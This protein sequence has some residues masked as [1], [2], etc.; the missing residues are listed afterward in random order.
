MPA[1]ADAPSPPSDPS[2][3][4]R[5]ISWTDRFIQA[6]A[7]AGSIAGIATFLTEHPTAGLRLIA[8]SLLAGGVALTFR[9]RTAGGLSKGFTGALALALLGAGAFGWSL[10]PGGASDASPPTP[11]PTTLSSPPATTRPTPGPAP[12]PGSTS[13]TVHRAETTVPLSARTEIDLDSLAPDWDIAGYDETGR[14]DLRFSTSSLE[15]I[16]DAQLREATG[17]GPELCQQATA[18]YQLTLGENLP[19]TRYT[20]A[21]TNE[22]R[23]ASVRFNREDVQH[24]Y[25]VFNRITLTI[26][27]Y[28]RPA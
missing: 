13:V 4:R 17:D 22:N 11:T 7:V 6:A 26:T 9:W 10:R 14:A 3:S 20:C 27:V 1:I 2:E 12:E 19:E 18:Q 24:G 23:F 25:T 8:V 21:I 5:K 16:N 15:A 28:N